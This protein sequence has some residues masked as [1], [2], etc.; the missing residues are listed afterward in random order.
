MLLALTIIVSL[1]FALRMFSS[2]FRHANARQPFDVIGTIL[3]D[4]ALYQTV[5]WILYANT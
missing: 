5:V 4:G 2:V 1:S 3:V